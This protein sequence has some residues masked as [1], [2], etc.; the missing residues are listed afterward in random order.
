ML[1]NSSSREL[2][3]AVFRNEGPVRSSELILAA[4]E[5]AALKWPHVNV[6]KTYV[7]PDKVKSPNP[8]YCFK[9][10]GWEFTGKT[11]RGLHILEKRRG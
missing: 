6:Y 3:C 11:K 8:G 2:H 4:E 5:I 1:N 9:M 7:N 10:A